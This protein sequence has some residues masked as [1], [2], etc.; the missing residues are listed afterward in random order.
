VV[1]RA[2]HVLSE[3]GCASGSAGAETAKASCLLSDG[4]S[5]PRFPGEPGDGE[6]TPRSARR[7]VSA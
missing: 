2:V 7:S 1:S 5:R 6:P 3:A 4:R